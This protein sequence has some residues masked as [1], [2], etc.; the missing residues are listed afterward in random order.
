MLD[1]EIFE[2]YQN[3]G[4]FDL[5]IYEK[6]RTTIWLYNYKIKDYLDSLKVVAELNSMQQNS[7]FTKNTNLNESGIDSFSK[8]LNSL[9]TKGHELAPACMTFSG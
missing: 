8:I 6:T 5:P 4:L 3:N 2:V 1:K 9:A 7:N